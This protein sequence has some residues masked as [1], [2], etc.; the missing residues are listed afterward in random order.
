MNT[1]EEIWRE[2]EN[3]KKYLEQYN[4][5]ENTEECLRYYNGDQWHGLKVPNN[6]E[7]PPILNIIE[8]VIKYKVGTVNSN[9]YAIQYTPMGY[10]EDYMRNE[11]LCSLLNQYAMTEWERLKMDSKLW[12]HT[13]RAAITGD[14]YAYFMFDTEQDCIVDEMIDNVSILFADEQQPDIQKQKYII[15]QERKLVSEIKEIAKA[16]KVKKADMDLITS[17]DDTEK[18]MG[19]KAKKEVKNDEDGKAILLTKFWK[20]DGVV[21]MLKT[22][23]NV[24]VHP[25]TAIIG[26]GAE[27]GM[28]LYPIA[29]FR[30]KEEHGACR[31][32]GDVLRLINNQREINKANARYSI[33]LKQ[34]AMPHIVYD[35]T[36][37]SDEEAD[38]I[39]TIGAKIAV[40]GNRMMRINE[41]INFLQPPQI[42]SESWSYAQTLLETTRNLAGAADAV[43]GNIDPTRASGVAI[44]AVQDA[45]ALPLNDQQASLKQFVEDVARI[46]IDIWQI[47]KGIMT[48]GEP[49][50]IL[51]EMGQPVLDEMGQEQIYMERRDFDITSLNYVVKVDVSPSNPYSK[52]SQEQTLLNFLTGGLISFEDYVEALPD[53]ASAPKS[54]LQRIVDKQRSQAMASQEQLAMEQAQMQQNQDN[55]AAMQ[56]LMQENAKLKAALAEVGNA[57]Q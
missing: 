26:E 27:V 51:D 19:D 46:W 23:K 42:S 45:A 43:T 1:P 4:Y 16:N 13:T 35:N 10:E 37:I 24:I 18:I 39:T 31:G 29:H 2:Y 52:Y 17:D 55:I 54:K 47:Y 36:A 14:S 5:Y 28:R 34:F 7:V 11:A 6:G 38:K 15:V 8:P 32:Q 20:E 49:E 48:I 12:T 56:S 9:G 53:D 33:I 30:W 25:D 21:H 41:L 50:P 44:Q 3:G 40:E 22:T 57:G